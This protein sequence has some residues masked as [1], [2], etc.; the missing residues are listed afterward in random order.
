M[1]ILAE[2]CDCWNVSDEDGDTP[3]M[4][5]LKGVKTEIVKS[6]VSCPRV[7]QNVKETLP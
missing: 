2:R 5:G 1:E 3:I 6:L 4:R 7:D